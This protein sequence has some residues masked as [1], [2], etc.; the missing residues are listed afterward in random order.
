[1]PH[2]TGL[3]LAEKLLKIRPDIPIILCTGHSTV[4]TEKA[5][6]EVGVKLFAMKPID[7]REMAV[8]V[9]QLLDGN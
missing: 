7:E 6:K 9:K 8:M 2:M 5:A 1:M 4:V 3:S